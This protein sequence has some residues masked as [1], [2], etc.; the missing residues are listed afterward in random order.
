MYTLFLLLD[1]IVFHN[2]YNLIILSNQDNCLTLTRMV[3]QHL[4]ESH[5]P[6]SMSIFK[7]QFRLD[8]SLFFD[9]LYRNTLH[10][11]YHCIVTLSIS[12]N[13]FVVKGYTLPNYDC[14]RSRFLNPC[15]LLIVYLLYAPS[16]KEVR[17]AW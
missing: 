2:K 10:Y 17:L 11:I 14:I 4:A 16:K 5:L 8:P 12:I 6:V 9:T 15:L 13:I 1:V 3:F 7:Y